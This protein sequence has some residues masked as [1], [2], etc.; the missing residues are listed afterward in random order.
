[1]TTYYWVGGTGTWDNASKTNWALTSGGTGGLVGPPTNTDNV[2]I[3]TS[4]GTGT[5]TCTSA[6]ATCQN[7]T[8]T[9][10][11]AITLAGTLSL[12]KGSLSYPSTGSFVSS[13][14]LTFTATTTGFTINTGSITISGQ[15]T[16]NGV[17]GGWT[18]AG[19]FSSSASITLTNGSLNTGN[20]AVN[21][22]VFTAALGTKSLT[23]GTSTVTLSGSGNV[24]DMATAITN[25]TFSGASSTIVLS[26][27]SAGFAGGGLTYNVVN[28]TSTALTLATITGA[29]T[30]S[31]L[32]FAARAASGIGSVTISANQTITTAFT[33]QSGATDPTR[34]L[35]IKS[36]VVGTQRT[37]T[38]ASN[39]LYAVDFQDINAAGIAVWSDSLRTQY[40]GNCKGNT[41]IT[42]SA[43][44]TAYWNL[45]GAQNWSAVGWATSSGGTPA[46]A[47]FPLAQDPVIFNNAGSVTGTILINANFNINSLDMSGRTSAAT[48]NMSTNAPTFYGD[49][50]LG[51]GSTFNGGGQLN[52]SGRTTQTI[53][54]A[55]KSLQAQINVNTLG[56]TVQLAD[57]FITSNVFVLINGAFNTQNHNLTASGFTYSG[58]T[59]CSITLGTSTVSLSGTGVVWN[60][61]STTG[62]TFSAASS[63]IA[64]TDTTTGG[65]SISG[66]GLTYGTLQ[67]GAVGATTGICTYGINQP[68]T[69]SAFT[70]FKTVAFTIQIQSNQTITIGTW[71]VTGS[72]GNVVTLNTNSAGTPAP[73][74]IAN[75]TSGIDYLDVTDITA[76]LAPVTF[77]AGANTKLRSNVRGVA[78]K[79]PTA[80]QYIYV[81][82]S[83][84]S[85]TTP[86]NWNNA[87]NEIHLFAGGGG[88]A[89]S[90]FTTPN[91][92]G[93]A[94]GGGG[95]Y[96]KATN[97][98]LSGSISYAIGAGGTAGGA[99]GNGGAGGSTTFNSGA[100]TTTG[101]GGGTGTATSS[102]GGTAGTGSTFNGGTGGIGSLS[103]VALT[104]N[105][106]GGGGGTGGPLGNGANGGNGFASTTALNIAGGGGGGNGGG[107]TGG[108]ASSATGGIGGNNNA[109]V[110]GGASATTGFNGGGGGGRVAAGSPAL[111]GGCGTDIA[112][113]GMGSGGGAGGMGGIGGAGTNNG[114]FGSGGA[115]GGLTIAN[116]TN[117]G[118]QG[119]QGGI[120]IVYTTGGSTTNKNITLSSSAAL[121]LLYNANYVRTYTVTSTSTPTI[122]KLLSLFR[123]ISAS[124]TGSPTISKLLSLFRKLSISSTGSPTIVKA[125][126]KIISLLSTATVTITKVPVKLLSVAS[127]ATVSIKRAISNI[128]NTISELS[129]VVLTESS[130]HL[131]LLS[132]TE[133]TTNTI[134]KAISITKSLS[135]TGAPSLFKNITKTLSVLSTS[136]INIVKK[137]GKTL[138]IASTGAASMARK[139]I[140]GKIMSVTVTATVSI[141]HILAKTLAVLSTTTIAINKKMSIIFS[142]ISATITTLILAFLPKLGA[143]VRYTFTAN[144]RD[145]L[146]QLFKQRNVRANESNK[147]VKK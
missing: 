122:S 47:N 42:F 75:R 62:L 9:A 33:V 137:V 88:G 121:S 32:S 13:A 44:Q 18:L 65:K 140:L 131:V 100:Y 139:F 92:S 112:N 116:A 138:S 117:G 48:L 55:G 34:R 35:F 1:M 144:M 94:G 89:G 82:A 103:T 127:T 28:F 74:I 25:L 90:Y 27:A 4:S 37:I 106:G 81:L 77:Y 72:A 128:M 59:A 134:K 118:G 53:T 147:K 124:V 23:L 125:I 104:G 141:A 19:N 54:S 67:F 21:A 86:A 105:G 39:T 71:A 136:V 109:G 145:S 7:L 87:N 17:G 79:A 46:A 36:D 8:V 70:S 130:F 96:T 26:N 16:F 69:F 58:T 143:V 63:T 2:I 78:A 108:N 146:I 43:G 38:S 64:F 60:T 98:T 30:Y 3:D 51:S 12:L 97:V 84:T 11:Q 114:L 132:V 50:T 61:T 15:V 99:G 24:W 101:A 22:T 68:N 83:G 45:A 107:S 29:N 49:F 110:G 120:I 66:G 52:L 129:V 113:A 73:L 142:V 91:G 10:T 5:I 76:N 56:G 80:N 6:S 85:F 133:V 102:T 115:G 111:Y 95:G 93:G 41:G 14:A 31:S 135:A 119:A 20:Y 57:D 126:A 123:T 40:W